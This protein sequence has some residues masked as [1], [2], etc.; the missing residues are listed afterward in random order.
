MLFGPHLDSNLHLH[1]LTSLAAKPGL[2]GVQHEL[3]L[4]KGGLQLRQLTLQLL[5]GDA[6]AVGLGGVGP[7]HPGGE[8]DRLAVEGV[9]A[10]DEAGDPLHPV[11]DGRVH[12]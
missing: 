6:V 5:D 3:L 10:L 11:A 2:E 1:R 8:L 4:L 12:C 9:P 7:V